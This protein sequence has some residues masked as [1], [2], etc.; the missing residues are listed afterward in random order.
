HAF[1]KRIS[2]VDQQDNVIESPLL[3]TEVPLPPVGG[4]TDLIGGLNDAGIV[5]LGYQEGNQLAYQ[6]QTQDPIQLN[7]IDGSKI[8]NFEVVVVGPGDLPG[9]LNRLNDIEVAKQQD[10]T[11]SFVIGDL[12]LQMFFNILLPNSD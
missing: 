8:T 12:A 4:I 5:L 9:D 6:E 2:Y 11:V 1:I 7:T 10:V 3:V